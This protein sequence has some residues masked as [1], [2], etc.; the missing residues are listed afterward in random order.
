[1]SHK[2]LRL[3]MVLFV[4]CGMVLNPIFAESQGDETR[5]AQAV[6]AGERLFE[7]LIRI[8]RIQGVCEVLNP[9]IGRFEL[10]LGDKAYPLGTTFRTDQA[11]QATLLLS[12]VDS[13]VLHGETEVQIGASEQ[14]QDTRVMRLSKGRVVFEVRANLPE[15]AFAI[16]TLNARCENIAGR[17]D[18]R[19]SQEGESDVFQAAT[20][21][22][23]AFVNGPNY[24]IPKLRAANTVNILTAPERRLS[25]LTS[26]SG[27]F[28]VVLEKGNEDP[29]KFGMSPKAVVKI[30]RENAPVGGNA[31][32]STLA[33]S[34]NGISR[35]RFAFVAGR[36][37]LATGELVEAEEEEIA[38]PA[39][40]SE[41]SEAAADNDTTQEQEG[42]GQESG[43]DGNS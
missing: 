32:I 15:G 9:D 7:P 2:M 43:G 31:V 28:D 24:K 27:D 25:R 20:I 19:V 34:P 8:I 29:I 38:L 40:L 39:L 37:D 36:A 42:A 30:W 21:T 18:Y 10:A 3:F 22:G 13:V 41:G 16:E 12:N 17:G 1:M 33:V 4:V 14:S 35:H 11:A 23:T 6:Q 26:V 5:K